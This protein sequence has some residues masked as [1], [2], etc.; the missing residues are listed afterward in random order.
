MHMI[1]EVDEG[2]QISDW[3]ENDFSD[4]LPRIIR[5]FWLLVLGFLKTENSI[6]TSDVAFLAW[7]D[8]NSREN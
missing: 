6:W 8:F 5:E 4:L 2:V 3:N 7:P 1:F